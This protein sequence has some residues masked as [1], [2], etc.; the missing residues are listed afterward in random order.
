MSPVALCRDPA[1]GQ[2]GDLWWGLVHLQPLHRLPQRKSADRLLA[3]S[4]K[5]VRGK[6]YILP[7]IR[8]G[9]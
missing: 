3:N 2:G 7:R 9:R 4:F 6:L 5:T 8:A 1:W